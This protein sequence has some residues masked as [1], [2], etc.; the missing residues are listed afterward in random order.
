MEV[1]LIT[2][3]ELFVTISCDLDDIVG[4]IFALYIL[5]L[6]A[7]EAALGLALVIAYYRLTAHLMI[8]L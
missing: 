6:G 7:C 3:F 5:V 2:N 8:S 1:I 4:S